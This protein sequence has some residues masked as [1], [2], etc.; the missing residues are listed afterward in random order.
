MRYLHH[1]GARRSDYQPPSAAVSRRLVS[2]LLAI[3]L[4]VNSVSTQ[5]L[6]KSISI[7]PCISVTLPPSLSL[8]LS[9]SLSVECGRGQ[10]SPPH[11]LYCCDLSDSLS[12]ALRQQQQ[13]CSLGSMLVRLA[14]QSPEVSSGGSRDHCPIPPSKAAGARSSVAEQQH[15]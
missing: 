13:N 9:L 8:S 1:R 7:S 6:S 4:G 12:S 5:S 14:R 15:K 10:T 3:A 2:D 11:S